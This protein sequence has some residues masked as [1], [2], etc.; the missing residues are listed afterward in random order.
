MRKV[1]GR[2]T[3][4]SCQSCSI[5]TLYVGHLCCYYYI[6]L[7]TN[8]ILVWFPLFIVHIYIGRVGGF[9]F[10]T[11]IGEWVGV[12]QTRNWFNQFL[13]MFDIIYFHLVE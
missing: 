5:L 13:C 11:G 3:D 9:K 12:N 10:N 2:S 1:V 4:S 8:H 6:M 7:H